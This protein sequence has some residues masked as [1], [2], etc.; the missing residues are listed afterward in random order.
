MCGPG[1]PRR[2]ED[3]PVAVED[4]VAPDELRAGRGVGEGEGA[5]RLAVGCAEPVGPAEGE[6]EF[7]SVAD[8]GVDIFSP[9]K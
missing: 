3:D 7:R 5:R 6:D 1:D 2:G 8:G 4:G 9:L